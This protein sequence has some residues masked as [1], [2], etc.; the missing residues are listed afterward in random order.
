MIHDE[1][2]RSWLNRVKK[3][4]QLDL[5]NKIDVKK[6]NFI[7]PFYGWGSTASRLQSHCEEIV[8]FLPLSSQKFLVL[9]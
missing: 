2:H 4:R 9:I 6:Q 8:Y 3:V 7:A 5:K 1:K